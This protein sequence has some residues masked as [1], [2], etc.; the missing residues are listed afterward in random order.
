MDVA[1]NGF[2]GNAIP[3]P[4]VADISDTRLLY[5]LTVGVASSPSNFCGY[6][7][8]F[9]MNTKQEMC[10]Y[11]IDRIRMTLYLLFS[12]SR[13]QPLFYRLGCLGHCQGACRLPTVI[14][15]WGRLVGRGGMLTYFFIVKSTFFLTTRPSIGHVFCRR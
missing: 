9:C 14:G 2:P 6:L 11:S 1:A 15:D 5:P 7:R 13:F 3:P 8:R 4:S 12:R 10:V